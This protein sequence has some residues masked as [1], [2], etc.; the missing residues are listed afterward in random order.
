MKLPEILN[1]LFK[2]EIVIVYKEEAVDLQITKKGKIDLVSDKGYLGSIFYSAP[3]VTP[4]SI[5]RVLR[6]DW[7]HGAVDF[8]K[9]NKEAVNGIREVFGVD[10]KNVSYININIGGDDVMVQPRKKYELELKA[11]VVSTRDNRKM[12]K[13]S[14]KLQ[15]PEEDVT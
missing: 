8:T 1:N 9:I 15:Q 10:L 3:R 13:I 7:G 4:S 2:E 6:R 5:T 14:G 11:D 12:L